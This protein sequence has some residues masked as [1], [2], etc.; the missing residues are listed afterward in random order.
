MS[1][2]HSSTRPISVSLVLPKLYHGT[3]RHIPIMCPQ[4]KPQSPVTL[5]ASSTAAVPKTTTEAPALTTLESEPQ[6]QMLQPSLDIVPLLMPLPIAAP[7]SLLHCGWTSLG[8]T[9][10]FNGTLAELKAHC[11][12]SHFAG[13][14]DTLIACQWKECQYYKRGDH[15]VNLMRRDSIWRHTCEK[16]LFLKRGSHAILSQCNS[17]VIV[18]W[19]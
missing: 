4:S 5:L 17:C 1:I 3:Q 12:A 2:M 14:K 9:C 15:A 10:P 13:P 18:H 6:W 11:R 16:H 19:R 8:V 7:H